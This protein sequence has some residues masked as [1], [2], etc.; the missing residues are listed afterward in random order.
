MKKITFLLLFVI[1]SF[2]ACKKDEEITNDCSNCGTII[3]ELPGDS[4][5][6]TFLWKDNSC[7]E[8][9]TIWDLK[10]HEPWYYIGQT[11]CKLEEI[12]LEDLQCKP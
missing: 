1:L 5:W 10:L 7:G 8:L 2:F 6:R 12:D 4:L 9:Y 3:K 11:V